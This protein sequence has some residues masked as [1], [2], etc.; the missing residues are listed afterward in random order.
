MLKRNVEKVKLR[1]DLLYVISFIEYSSNWY[2]K[3]L[4]N[5][6]N[7]K[8]YNMFQTEQN[9]Q[10][11]TSMCIEI[12]H[13]VFTSMNYMYSEKGISFICN[14]ILPKHLTVS[15]YI[16]ICWFH[17]EIV[18]SLYSESGNQKMIHFETILQHR[19][20]RQSKM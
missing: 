1:N 5:Y 11:T 12:I 19:V 10:H 17:I 14:I 9:C 2:H 8:P 4:R 7:F 18:L 13:F 3:R 20:Q 16:L 15:L 6:T